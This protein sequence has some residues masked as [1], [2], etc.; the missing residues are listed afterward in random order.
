M[1]ERGSWGNVKAGL[2]NL[3]KSAASGVGNFFNSLKEDVFTPK[4]LLIAGLTAL[5][6]APPLGVFLL[7]LSAI[8]K[9]SEYMSKDD[10]PELNKLDRDALQKIDLDDLTKS[11]SKSKE[12][13]VGQGEE[14]KYKHS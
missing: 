10:N 4:R 2:S 1:D 6:F 8:N 9:I 3:G 14:K 12:V 11:K 7:V 13:G 5:A